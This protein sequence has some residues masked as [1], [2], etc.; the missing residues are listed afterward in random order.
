MKDLFSVGIIKTVWFN[1]RYLP[2]KQAVHLPFVLARNVRLIS[3]ERGFC[4][5]I[6]G[7]YKDRCCN[8]WL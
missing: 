6:G 4:E 3:C 8:D 1:F 2:F 7:G 5:F